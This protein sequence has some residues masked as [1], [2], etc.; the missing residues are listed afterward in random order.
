[1]IFLLMWKHSMAPCCPP[2]DRLDPKAFLDTQ[3]GLLLDGMCV[4][5]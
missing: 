5:P 3:V 4:R 1:M 2:S